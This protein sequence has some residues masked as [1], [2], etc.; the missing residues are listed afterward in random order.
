MPLAASAEY[1]S[2]GVEHEGVSHNEIKTNTLRRSVAFQVTVTCVPTAKE[3]F[4]SAPTTMLPGN[5]V[6]N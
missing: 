6:Q 3:E 1:S 2:A 5:N 4:D